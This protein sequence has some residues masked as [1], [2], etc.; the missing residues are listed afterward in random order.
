MISAPFALS[1][2]CGLWILAC[3]LFTFVCCGGRARAVEF[4]AADS[5]EVAKAMRQAAA[6][7]TVILADGEW[8]DADLL[9]VGAGAEDKPITIRP[10]TPGKVILCGES[11]LRLCG[12]YLQV[13]DLL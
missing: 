4:R 9:V 8:R 12:A 13:E 10:A 7:D 3:V 5:A 1:S 6:G 11:H 2:L